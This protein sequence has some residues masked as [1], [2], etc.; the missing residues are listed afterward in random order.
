MHKKDLSTI[1]QKVCSIIAIVFGL[2]TIWVGGTTLLGFSDP[3]Y[4]I[5]LPL[6]IFNTVMGFA[7]T[8]AGYLIWRKLQTGINAA[9]FVFLINLSV[10]ILIAIAYLLEVS[11]AI[12]SLKAMSFRTLIWAIIYVI[13]VKQNG[14]PTLL[15]N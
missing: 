11:I 13:L 10:L 3:G 5:F 8:A 6:L 7:Y 9:K 4:V 12:E 2:I 14:K 15:S 1:I